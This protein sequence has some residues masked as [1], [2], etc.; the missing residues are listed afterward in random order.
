VL[1]K[2]NPAIRPTEFDRWMVE[3]L[4]GSEAPAGTAIDVAFP[5]PSKPTP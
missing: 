4:Y 1:A 2:D 5:E 3:T